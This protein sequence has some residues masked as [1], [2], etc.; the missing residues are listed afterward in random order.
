MWQRAKSSTIY[1]E[2]TS[3]IGGTLLQTGS[4]SLYQRCCCCLDKL[5]DTDVEEAEVATPLTGKEVGTAL[6]NDTIAI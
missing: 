5:V 3:S 6:S 1:T 2:P 4:D